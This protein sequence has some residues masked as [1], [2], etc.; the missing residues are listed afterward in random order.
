MENVFSMSIKERIGNFIFLK[1]QIL[2]DQNI[3]IQVNFV[4]TG[5]MVLIDDY[6]QR[7]LVSDVQH[8]LSRFELSI[9]V[10]P[11]TYLRGIY[12]K[13]EVL[14]LKK[15]NMSVQMNNN[16]FE[17]KL[18]IFW[19]NCGISLFHNFRLRISNDSLYHLW[20]FLSFINHMN[21]IELKVKKMKAVLVNWIEK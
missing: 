1:S 21:Y 7:I 18:V 16:C 19:Y 13:G 8:N 6:S 3:H 10:T 11:K 17:G 4:W 2:I 14:G 12:A 20:Y 5:G 9:F 15:R